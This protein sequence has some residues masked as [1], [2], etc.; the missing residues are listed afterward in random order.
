MRLRIAVVAALIAC[1]C[2][3]PEARFSDEQIASLAR[4]ALK[5]TPEYGLLPG[6]RFGWVLFARDEHAKMH[7]LDDRIRAELAKKYTVYSVD[8]E[9][10]AGLIERD[11]QGQPAGYRDG[12]WFAV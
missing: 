2:A 9:V 5:H 7:E 8:R 10:P 6:G 3:A 11:R 12:F 1:S 4:E